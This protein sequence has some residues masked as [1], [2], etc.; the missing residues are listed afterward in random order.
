M[1]KSDNMALTD[2]EIRAIKEVVKISVDEAIDERELVT[3]DDL[4]YLPTKDEFYPR[5]DEVM[6]ELKTIREEVF[7]TNHS[8]ENHEDR[9]EKMETHLGLSTN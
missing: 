9:I 7:A 6:G 3:K 5:M 2:D 4:K 8:L 1:F